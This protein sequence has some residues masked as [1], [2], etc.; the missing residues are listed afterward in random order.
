[1][2]W[3]RKVQQKSW[4][5]LWMVWHGRFYYAMA[6]GIT[7]WICFHT[8]ILQPYWTCQWKRCCTS[9]NCQRLYYRKFNV[10]IIEKQSNINFDFK[11]VLK[12]LPIFFFLNI[13]K[14]KMDIPFKNEFRICIFV[15]D[16]FSSKKIWL[17]RKIVKNSS[18]CF[19]W[20]HV[21]GAGQIIQQCFR[22]TS[23][24]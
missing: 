7:N 4:R 3:N 10:T 23:V 20:K 17:T 18:I 21:V 24:D 12:T 13:E 9:T 5:V 22:M 2:Y 6:S 16:F 14:L 15:I 11:K 1:M 19:W 8:N